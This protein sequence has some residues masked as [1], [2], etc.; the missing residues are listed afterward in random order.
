MKTNVPTISAYD[1]I[2]DVV[3][4]LDTLEKLVGGTLD[5]ALMANQELESIAHIKH[6]ENGVSAG[7]DHDPYEPGAF[8]K[9]LSER[10]ECRGRR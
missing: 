2:Y 10:V 1:V 8:V 5:E 6:A 4:K 3:P 9:A 7:T